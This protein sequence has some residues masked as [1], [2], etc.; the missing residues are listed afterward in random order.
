MILLSFIYQT[1]FSFEVLVEE[2]L[3]GSKDLSLI[4]ILISGLLSHDNTDIAVAAIDV[5]QEL[6]DVDTMNE[7]DEGAE[8]LLQEREA[9]V[10]H[11]GAFKF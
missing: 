3:G 5:I 8:A 10:D 1:S 9:N 4:N 6:T 2:I 7:S 11:K